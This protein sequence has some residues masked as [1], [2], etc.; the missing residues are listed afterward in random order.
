MREYGL[1]LFHY[2]G[3]AEIARPRNSE[4][5]MFRRAGPSNIERVKYLTRL[6]GLVVTPRNVTRLER[7]DDFV[8]YWNRLHNVPRFLA[9]ELVRRD[10]PSNIEARHA[11]LESAQAIMEDPNADPRAVGK[12]IN[13]IERLTRWV[14]KLALRGMREKKKPGPP[15]T[16]IYLGDRP[17]IQQLGPPDDGDNDITWEPYD[18]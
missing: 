17:P 4:W 2:E 8:E 5:S 12:A 16:V 14:V 1:W 9:R 11:A 7:R 3:G 15:A 13:D 10:L 18:P 6:T